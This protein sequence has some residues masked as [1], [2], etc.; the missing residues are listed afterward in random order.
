MMINEIEDEQNSRV[1][2]GVMARTWASA[3]SV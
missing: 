3:N 2:I 1:F